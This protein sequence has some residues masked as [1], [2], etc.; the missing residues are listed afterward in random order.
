MQAA[1]EEALEAAELAGEQVQGFLGAAAAAAGV[2][3]AAAAAAAGRGAAATL[4]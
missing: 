2:Q 1:E 3:G 4:D